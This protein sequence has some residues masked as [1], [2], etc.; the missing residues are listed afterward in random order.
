MEVLGVEPAAVIEVV[1][2][3][4]MEA[5]E[6][7]LRELARQRYRE[8]IMAAHPDRGGDH[9][10]AAKLNEAREIIARVRIGR[11]PPRRPRVVVNVWMRYTPAATET[12]R[13]RDRGRRPRT[14]ECGDE[15]DESALGR[16]GGMD[17]RGGERNDAARKY[18]GG[19]TGD[20]AD[21]RT[22]CWRPGREIKGK[23]LAMLRDARVRKI[24]V[25]IE[26]T[27]E[28]VSFTEYKSDP[29]R[30]MPAPP[31]VLREKKQKG[32]T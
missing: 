24:V 9:T 4:G 5:A 17:R 1:Y 3:E 15:A 7:K 6:R 32:L 12:R 23:P 16:R 14:R 31:P 19:R 18:H 28:R 8:R 21:R 30:W 22:E 11:E 25:E 29:S 10:L 13:H 20:A 2:R 26:G 27:S